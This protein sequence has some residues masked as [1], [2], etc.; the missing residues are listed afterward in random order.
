MTAGCARAQC[1]QILA[2]FVLPVAIGRR[3]G[4]HRADTAPAIDGDGEDG[5]LL[6]SSFEPEEVPSGVHLHASEIIV[7]I[8][9]ISE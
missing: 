3:R 6:Q 1:G 2:R 5:S 7:S 8:Q 9:S 4:V